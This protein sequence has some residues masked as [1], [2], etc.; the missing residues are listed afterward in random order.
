MN[1]S[2]QEAPGGVGRRLRALPWRGPG[3]AFAIFL[4]VLVVVGLLAYAGHIRDGGFYYDDWANSALYHYPS[5][6]GFF[7]AVHDL[8]QI[9]SYRPALTVYIPILEAVFG[10][11]MGFHLAWAFLLALGMSVSLFFFLGALGLDAVAAGTIAV[12]VLVF[13]SS[14]ATRLWATSSMASLAIIFYCLGSLLALRGLRGPGRGWIAHAGAVLLYAVSIL[15]YEIAAGP[16]LLSVLVYRRVTSWRRAA[17]MWL[18]DLVVVVPILLLVTSNN[19]RGKLTLSQ[20]LHH[21]RKIADQGLSLF[22]YAAAPIG[23]P[24]RDLVIAV[25]LAVIA[26]AAVVCRLLPK[27]DPARVELKRWLIVVPFAVLGTA[28]AWLVFVPADPYYSPGEPGVGNRVNVLAAV[29]IVTLVYALAAMVGTLFFRGLPRWRILS[30]TFAVLAS[31]GI[32]IGY[33]HTLH[34]DVGAYNRAF[35][36][37]QSTLNVLKGRLGKPPPGSTIYTFNQPGYA[38]PGVPIFASSW[39][40]NGAVKITFHDGSLR[41]YPVIQG[42]PVQC[43]AQSMGVPVSGYRQSVYGRSYFV[44]I[45]S[46]R[47]AR[48]TSRHACNALLGSFPPGPV[49]LSA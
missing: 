4:V 47:V 45:A 15:L 41:A 48:V 39:D 37:E 34:R 18:V 43:G 1:A 30:S 31:V 28:L 17:Y 33:M 19:G 7:G 22:A 6:H 2:V 12:L 24:K 3:L 10:Y 38:A 25:V 26:C 46:G 44:D 21:V 5:R 16:I 35:N 9:S 13:P 14:D 42:V 29:G 23:S 40:L 8:W 27:L 36:L 20:E 32:G 11:H 49:I